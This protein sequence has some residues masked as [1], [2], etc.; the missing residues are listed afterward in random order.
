MDHSRGAGRIINR[1]FILVATAALITAVLS[2]EYFILKGDG[3]FVVAGDFNRQ[4]LCFGNAMQHL[5]HNRPW[6]EWVW[7]LDLGSSF[8]TGFGYYDLGSPFTLLTTLFPSGSFPYIAGYSYILKYVA[9]SLFAFLYLRLF[10]KEEKW[11]VVGAL[12]YSF[13][14][15]QTINL[16]FYTFHDVV[17]FFPLL[18]LA[19]EYSEKDRKYR[20]F[21]V[22]AV[23]LN[24]F[25][26]YFFFVQEVLLLVL[27]FLFRFRGKSRK[28][29][30]GSV[31]AYIMCGALGT[32]MAAALFLPNVLYIFGN[33]RAG[34]GHYLESLFYG[35][36]DLLFLIK[37]MLF[38]AEPMKNQSA[39][40]PTQFKSTSCYLPLFGMTLVIEYIRRSKGWLRSLLICLFGISLSPLLQSG[41][42]LFTATYQR[43]WFMLI[44]MMSLATI[45]VLDEREKY[46][47]VKSILFCMAAAAV[48]YL[49]L[50]HMNWSREEGILVFDKGQF[51]NYL[52]ITLLSSALVLFL[53]RLKKR[54]FACVLAATMALCVVTTAYTLHIYRANGEGD[55][56]KQ[57]FAVGMSLPE[58]DAQFRYNT[59]YN[60]YSITA[61]KSSVACF[62][63]TI[64]NSSRKL[65]SLFGRETNVTNDYRFSVPGLP[66]LLAG[67]YEITNNVQGID[68]ENIYAQF[69][70]NDSEYYVTQS[71]AFPIGFAVD[72]YIEYDVLKEAP[73]EIKAYIMMD[74]FAVMPEDVPKVTDAAEKA[75][76]TDYENPD[77]E[78]MVE[79]TGKKAVKDFRRDTKG[80]ACRT[81]Y[82][83]DRYVYFSVPYDKGWSATVDGNTAEVIE[84]GGMMVLF[85]P[86]GEHNIEFVYHTPGFRAG[87]ML[88]GAA[89]L[90]FFVYCFYVFIKNRSGK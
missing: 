2:F 4:N 60:L 57:A 56:E 19:L 16:M 17:A 35:G 1:N 15:F 90:A 80:F 7:G 31:A 71:A 5:F 29:F 88:S 82:E 33:T 21:F 87:V 32:G 23:F 51:R 11:A 55:A 89:F 38:P 20:L 44:L 53:I 62:S 45:K 83:K 74:A 58:T 28:E 13:S 77:P 85:V 75:D 39:I 3:F 41:F 36:K 72:R 78:A 14:G 64:E 69:T 34:N 81:E 86:E 48:L 73:E 26:N 65:D 52:A 46:D 61:N 76:L 54:Y 37:S 42:L 68:S 25:I 43:W 22:F 50:C 24:C 66:Q 70:A 10:V 27:Y 6:G 30:I 49:A 12:L 9:A 47:P 63:S 59:G 8:I 67:K 79:E 18:L 84:S 40:L